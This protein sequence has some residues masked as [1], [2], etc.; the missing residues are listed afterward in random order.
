MRTEYF[1]AGKDADQHL[2]MR[3]RIIT[4]LARGAT[5]PRP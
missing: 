3:T 2:A 1:S 5:Y 4:G